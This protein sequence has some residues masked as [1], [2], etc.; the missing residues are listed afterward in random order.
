MNKGLSS[1]R[2]SCVDLSDAHL[3]SVPA[4]SF[5]TTKQDLQGLQ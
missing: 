5:K 4:M 2:W 1:L 3:G